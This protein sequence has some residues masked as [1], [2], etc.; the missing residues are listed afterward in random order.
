MKQEKDMAQVE[1]LNLRGS[2]WYVRILVPNDLQDAYGTAR[3]N[4][5]L[6]T[7]ERPKAILKATQKRADGCRAIK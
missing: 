4:I 7:S 3:K 1:G 5:S 2:R 6:D